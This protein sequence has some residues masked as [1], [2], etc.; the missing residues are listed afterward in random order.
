RQD[1]SSKTNG[2]TDKCALRD[3]HAVVGMVGLQLRKYIWDNWHEMEACF[4]VSG[5]DDKRSYWR[6]NC[7]NRLQLRCLQKQIGHTLLRHWNHIRS[8]VHHRLVS[9]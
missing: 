5:L 1:F 8:R 9:K 7:W 6:W 4:K 2:F 3:F